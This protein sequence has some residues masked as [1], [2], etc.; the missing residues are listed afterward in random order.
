MRTAVL[1]GLVGL[2]ASMPALAEGPAPADPTPEGSTGEARLRLET[3]VN[4]YLDTRFTA[5]HLRSDSLISTA[6]TPRLANLTEGNFQLKL[7]WGDKGFALADASFFYQG[8][9]DYPGP[10]HDVAAYHSLAV[11]SELYGSYWLTPHAN[12]TLGKKR[13]V[14]G[15][16]FV[17][18]PTDLLN[19]PKDPTDPSLQRAGAWLARLEFPYDKVTLSFVG[20]AQVLSESGGVPT[21]LLFYPSWNRTPPAG[22]D[23]THFAAA[24]RFYALIADTDVNVE[25]TFTNLYN[26]AF[27]KKS[28]VGLSFSRIVFKALEVHVEALGQLG[29][30]RAY[31]DPAC[32]ID[33]AAA[34]ACGPTGL[35]PLSKLGSKTPVVRGLAGARYTFDD[36]SMLGADYALYTD[37]FDDDQWRAFLRG[38]ALARANGLPTASFLGTPGGAGGG[39]PQKFTFQPLRRQ[40]LVA[41]YSK[42]RIKDDFT[43]NVTL[44]ASLQDLSAQIAPQVVWQIEEWVSVT[45]QGFIPLPALNPTDVDGT[46]YGE[47]ALAPSD[48]RALAS[49]RVFY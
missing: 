4:G 33:L 14:W 27:R 13:V 48:W 20:A 24:A 43:L 18:N 1:A 39:T 12:L 41:T 45:V 29:S 2:A 34:L 28:R 30:A 36:E 11:I 44:I 21:D 32:V 31:V 7:R 8:A 37:G 46:A 17:I 42:P 26:D 22:D 25:Y 38:L 16:G 49:L 35:A 47:F 19:P 9:G 6:D 5:Q 10:D 40:Y 23:Q 15:P 3:T